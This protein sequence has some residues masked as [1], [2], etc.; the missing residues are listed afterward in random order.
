MGKS[1]ACGIH[2]RDTNGLVP[3]ASKQTRDQPRPALEGLLVAWHTRQQPLLSPD[4]VEQQSSVDQRKTQRAPHRTSGQWQR[5]ELQRN[6]Q[7]VRVADEPIRPTADRTKVVRD[8]SANVPR[9]TERP[10]APPA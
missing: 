9:C 1:D 3:R 7:V 10:D 8:H 2:T 6:R 4:S 5:K